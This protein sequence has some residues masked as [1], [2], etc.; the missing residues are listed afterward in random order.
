[1]EPFVF[2]LVY[3]LKYKF[4]AKS[5]IFISCHLQLSLVFLEVLYLEQRSDP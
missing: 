1:M 5:F 3:L 4:R 2:L